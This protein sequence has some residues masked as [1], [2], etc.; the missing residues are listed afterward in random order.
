MNA[1]EPRKCYWILRHLSLLRHVRRKPVLPC[2]EIVL[3]VCFLVTDLAQPKCFIKSSL[4]HRKCPVGKEFAKYPLSSNIVE[5][6]QHCD[7]LTRD[8]IGSCSRFKVTLCSG[9]LSRP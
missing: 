6:R 9:E 4:I 2:L 7:V 8:V 1:Y 5:S 3:F